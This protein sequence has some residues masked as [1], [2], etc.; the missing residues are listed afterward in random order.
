MDK[1]KLENAVRGRV[2]QLLTERKITENAL[3]AGDAAAQKRLNRQLSPTLGHN[4]AITLDTLLRILAICPDVSADWLLRG[5]DTRQPASEY[6]NN[7]NGENVGVKNDADVINR[8]L[9]IIEEKDRQIAQL[10]AK[11]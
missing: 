10:I 9:S 7:I 4:A 3:A 5:T 8:F 11:L 2:A 6:Y 1:E